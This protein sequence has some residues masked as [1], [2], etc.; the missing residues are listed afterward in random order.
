MLYKLHE[1]YLEE[2]RPEYRKLMLDIWQLLQKYL[3]LAVSMATNNKCWIFEKNTNSA[4]VSS[5]LEIEIQSWSQTNHH[6][7]HN[8]FMQMNMQIN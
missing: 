2:D 1:Y 4:I 6:G 5:V 3:F 8:S 7:H